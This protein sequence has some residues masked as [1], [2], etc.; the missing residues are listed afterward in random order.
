MTI[1]AARVRL[2][3][4]DLD[5]TLMDGVAG[6]PFDG[7]AAA[8]R[9]V[10]ASGRAVRFVTNATSRPHRALFESL[11]DAGLADAPEDVWN[12]VS[13]ARSLL[14]ARGHDRGLLLV[15]EASRED[16]GWFTD[17]PAGPAVVVATEAHDRTIADLQ[18]AFRRLLEGAAL[19][20]LQRNRYYRKDGALWTDLGP[21][22]AF[23]RYA[24][25]VDAV[26]TLGKPSAAL[27][28][29]IAAD[30]GVPR[31]SILMVGDDAEFDVRGSLALEM[32][33]A[34]VRT[35]KYRPGDETRLD[36]APSAVL[37]SITSLPAALDL[38]EPSP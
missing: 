7:A 22:A 10:R 35:G 23:L 9:A 29:R 31:A 20:T 33:A 25:D 19:Y 16:W 28:D 8:V 37:D 18:P 34:L 12:P 14:P 36:P 5:G 17:D 1:D 3:C 11:R 30:A 21:L 24:A 32:Q 4:L 38:P 15:D 2:V 27:F 26:E 6:A 13:T